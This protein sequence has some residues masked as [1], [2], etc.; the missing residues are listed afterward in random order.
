MNIG[1]V[2]VLNLGPPARNRSW[3]T[4]LLIFCEIIHVMRDPRGH[5]SAMSHP[6]VDVPARVISALLL[7][8]RIWPGP[9]CVGF[10]S[11]K[12]TQT[13]PESDLLEQINM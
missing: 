2:V 1:N 3:I 13:R 9:K 5:I 12:A 6:V 7:V 10:K 4:C 8:V 11:N